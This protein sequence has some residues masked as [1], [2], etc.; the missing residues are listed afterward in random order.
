[1]RG[2]AT[3]TIQE[4]YTASISYESRAL[5]GKGA[6]RD[7]YDG[8]IATLVGEN[9]GVS[10]PFKIPEQERPIAERAKA[11]L[12]ECES[13]YTKDHGIFRPKLF[14]TGC[15]ALG[16]FALSPSVAVLY[17][18]MFQQQVNLNTF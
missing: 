15:P 10:S 3:G 14:V 4:A 11:R 13:P 8:T 16:R 9:G 2:Q 18:N 5:M 7:A 1:M 12:D 17:Q 6:L